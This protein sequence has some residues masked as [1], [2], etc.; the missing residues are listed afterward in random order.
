M[1]YLT[2]LGEHSWCSVLDSKD[3]SL[4][5]YFLYP[6]CRSSTAAVCFRMAGPRNTGGPTVLLDSPASRTVPSL[7]GEMLAGDLRNFT[8]NEGLLLQYVDD[9]LI[10][11]PS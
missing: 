10:A 1:R 5:P 8:L 3:V 2:I 7:F 11:S 6:Y 9:L 4:H